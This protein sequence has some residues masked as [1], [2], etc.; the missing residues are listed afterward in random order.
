[1]LFSQIALLLVVASIFGITAKFLRQPLLVGYL[2]AGILLSSL[3]FVQDKELLTSLSQIGVALLLFLLGLEMNLD[4]L[5]T[6]GKA[7][8]YTGIGQILL[9]VGLGYGLA[10]LLGFP[11]LPALYIA[12]ALAFSSTIIMV[13][14]LSEKKDLNSLYGKIAVGFLLVQDVVAIFILLFLA[15]TSTGEITPLILTARVVEAVAVFALIWVIS[16][17]VL[18]KLFDMLVSGNSELLFVASIAWA[19]GVAA[20]FEGPL[21]FSFEIGGFVAGLALSNLP[22]H[23]QIATRTRPLRDFFLTLFFLALGANLAI[24]NVGAV[25]APAI[26]LSLF[27]LLGNPIV[28]MAIMGV[29]GYKRR[30]SFMAGL[31]VAQISEFSLILVA[32]GLKLGHVDAKVAALVVMVGVITMTLSTYMITYAD[33]LYKVLNRWLRVF[34]RSKTLEDTLTATQQLT[35]HVVIVG[36]D[37][38]GMA[39]ARFF[40]KRGVPIVVV[41]FNPRVFVQLTAQKI[42]TLFGDIT[43]DDVVVASNLSQ[44]SLV[45]STVSSL[46]T[47]LKILSIIKQYHSK[48]LSVFTPSTKSDAMRLYEQKA[49][50]VTVPQTIAGD[51]LKHLFRTYGTGQKKLAQ[52][53]KSHFKRVIQD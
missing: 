37:K 6:I 30:T 1:M 50:Y 41:D 48:P 33:Y 3:G 43:D 23:L 11:S 9:T 29:L 26:L 38:T 53:G 45:I 47:N 17:R 31:T 21:G 20:L 34:E 25:L 18:P 7:A 36:A 28:V 12:I 40:Q 15:A 49:T 32:L 4:D 51:H 5:K 19:L 46:A 14:L 8:L 35:G 24:E 13:K 44:A 16:K 42:P 22:A 2:A 39:M 52:L 27:V 10:L